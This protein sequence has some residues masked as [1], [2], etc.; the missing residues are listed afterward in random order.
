MILD[1]PTSG[2]DPETRRELWNIL[3]KLKK[4]RIVLITTHFMEEA[5]ALADRIAIIDHGKL[6]CY[7]TPMFLKTLYGTLF[8]NRLLIFKFI[9]CWLGSGYRLTL[10]R[11]KHLYDERNPNGNQVE[12]I[13]NI[14][15]GKLSEATLFKSNLNCLT[16]LLPYDQKSAY[17][18]VLSE[19]ENNKDDLCVT[20]IEMSVTTLK[21]VFLK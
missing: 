18:E 7:G 5:E 17:G 10:I 3:L 11:D 12:T 9:L 14:V 8:E 13:T 19:I 16:Y 20:H 6:T 4:N 2:L 21:E 1:E 15:K